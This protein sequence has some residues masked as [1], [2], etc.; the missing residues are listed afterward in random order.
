MYLNSDGYNFTDKA[1]NAIWCLV[2]IPSTSAFCERKLSN[3]FKLQLY[4]TNMYRNISVSV[5]VNT[6]CCNIT[7]AIFFFSLGVE[8]AIEKVT[9]W[10]YI[11]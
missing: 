8:L 2:N 4:I 9:Y 11:M 6:C 5:A 7:L 3:Y 10:K 1:T